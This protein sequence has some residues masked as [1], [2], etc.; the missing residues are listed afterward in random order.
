MNILT[1]FFIAYRSLSF[2]LGFPPF[3]CPP[4]L[5]HTDGPFF[6]RIEQHCSLRF[7]LNR[8]TAFHRGPLG[9]TSFLKYKVHN[10]NAYF[11]ACL[12]QSKLIRP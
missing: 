8:L 3:P 11:K 5:D 6:R 12:L 9:S 4:P 7:T 2:F 10:I 1:P